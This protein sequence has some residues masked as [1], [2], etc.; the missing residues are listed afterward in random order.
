L[1]VSASFSQ[2]INP[3]CLDETLDDELIQSTV[4]PAAVVSLNVNIPLEDFWAFF[5]SYP[6]LWPSWNYLFSEV[7]NTKLDICQPLSSYFNF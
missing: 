1:C 4:S 7:N 5:A 2:Q 3:P 6:M